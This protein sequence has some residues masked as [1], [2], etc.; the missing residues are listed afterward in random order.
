MARFRRKDYEIVA[1]RATRRTVV[2]TFRGERV[3]HPGDWILHGLSG[4]RWVMSDLV[5]RAVYDPID[6]EARKLL[7]LDAPPGGSE[8]P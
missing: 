3:A 2:P 1:E 6:D 8:E 5:F 4:E 7:S